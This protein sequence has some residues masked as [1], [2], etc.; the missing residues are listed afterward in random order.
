VRGG[1][2]TAAAERLAYLDNLR[3]LLIVLVVLH[4]LGETYTDVSEWYYEEPPSG[5]VS[6]V[7]LLFVM[8]ASQSFFMGMFFLIA[9]YFAR[10]RTSRRSRP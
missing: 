9:G 2:E 1:R 6:S 5:A 7:V 3:V 8:A 10:R 4:H